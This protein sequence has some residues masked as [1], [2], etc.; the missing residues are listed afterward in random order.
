MVANVIRVRPGPALVAVLCGM[1]LT[2]MRAA[3]TVASNVNVDL[4]PGS[5]HDGIMRRASEFSNWVK[6]ARS[7]P[8]AVSK[9]I[10]KRPAGCVPMTPE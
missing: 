10:A 6:S 1:L 9:S 5:S 3:G 8:A 2:T 7:R 4:K